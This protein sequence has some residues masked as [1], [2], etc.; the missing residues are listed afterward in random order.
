MLYGGTLPRGVPPFCRLN[1][2]H[3]GKER[4]KEIMNQVNA[5]PATLRMVAVMLA[6][7]LALCAAAVAATPRAAHAAQKPAYAMLYSDNTLVF[8]RGDTPD[9]SHGELEEKIADVEKASVAAKNEPY[10]G[11]WGWG[12]REVKKVIFKDRIR[13]ASLQYWFA[14]MHNLESIENIGNLDTSCA[15]SMKGMFEWCEQLK[16]VDL[17]GFDTSRVTDMSNMFAGCSELR[18]ADLASFDTSKVTDMFGMFFECSKLSSVNVTS[19]DTSKVK[20]FNSMFCLTEKLK[21]INLSSFT[22]KKGAKAAFFETNY[23]WTPWNKTITVSTGFKGALELSRELN[24]GR[25]N[26][27][28]FKL[29]TKKAQSTNKKAVAVTKQGVASV[30]GVGT[31]KLKGPQA[32]YTVKVVPA[33]VVSKKPAAAKKGFTAKWKKQSGVDGYKIQWSTDKSFKKAVKSKT[34]KGAKK[35]SLKVGKLATKKTYY[36]RVCA[37]KKVSGKTYCS[38]WSKTQ[39]VKTK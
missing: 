14:G 8:Q 31:A 2:V 26:G 15:T 17:S 10:S 13:P 9:A 22:V 39:A 36:V 24:K 11:L 33:Q 25:L 19:F 35:T 34:V 23:H 30:K 5:K 18:K 3:W 12:T 28:D 20:N 27:L 32:T 38:A 37:Y 6:A 4:K 29:L 21:T 1:C 16:S 7:L